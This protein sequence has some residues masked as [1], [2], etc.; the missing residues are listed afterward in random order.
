MTTPHPTKTRLRHFE[1]V[2][3]REIRWYHFVTPEAINNVTNRTRTDA[4]RQLLAGELVE[5]P[6]AEPGD[7]SRVE[8][9]RDGLLWYREATG[10]E[11]PLPPKWPKEGVS[12]EAM[13]AALVAV[14]NDLGENGPVATSPPICV[15]CLLARDVSQC[16][17]SHGHDMCH[18]CYRLTHFVEV[19]SEECTRC[20]AENLPKILAGGPGSTS[21]EP[22]P[23]TGVAIKEE[24][25]RRALTESDPEQFRR[26][27]LGEWPD[28]ASPEPGPRVEL[29][30]VD[31]TPYV[32]PG[33]LNPAVACH[34]NPELFGGK[35]RW[36]CP[37]MADGY[38]AESTKDGS[39]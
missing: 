29:N 34:C 27:T 15:R 3:R 2:S 28:D 12:E 32:M 22:G 26:E 1:E 9:T 20:K 36:S 10:K 30:G 6:H 33:E 14:F 25:L 11:A 23:A 8:P 19:C 21:P 17:S 5:I 31:I 7:Y 18:R 38:L 16:C 37:A 4:V 24:D 35:H 13:D 39:E